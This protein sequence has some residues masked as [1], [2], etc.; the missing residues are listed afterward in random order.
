VGR[1]PH[2]RESIEQLIGQFSSSNQ[3]RSSKDSLTDGHESGGKIQAIHYRGPL[4]VWDISVEEDHS[5]WAEGVFNH[6]SDSPNQQNL[7][8][9]GNDFAKYIKQMVAAPEGWLFVGADFSSLEDKIITLLTRDPNRMKVYTGHLI[10][11]LDI[12]GVVHHIRDDSTIVYDG[13]T[14]TGEQ[15]YEWWNS[16][17]TVG[18]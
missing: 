15:F 3:C 18:C 7:P 17:R 9:S 14:Y 4:Q 8:S 12:D 10:Y 13:K 2:R 16:N 5:Y 1:T 6:N 11:E